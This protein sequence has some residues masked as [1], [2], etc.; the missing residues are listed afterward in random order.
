MTA[1]ASPLILSIRKLGRMCVGMA[2]GAVLEFCDGENV[3]RIF[4]FFHDL[5]VTLF[6]LHR[7]VFSP[8]RELSERM[9]EFFCLTFIPSSSCVAALTRLIEFP[10]MW[11]AV[12]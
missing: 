3:N 6:A 2:I 8:E 7:C 9:I 1:F 12:T 5:R 10:P 4:P 11:I